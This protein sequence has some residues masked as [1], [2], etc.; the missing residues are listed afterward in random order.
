MPRAE[1]QVNPLQSPSPAGWEQL[2]AA[3]AQSGEAAQKANAPFR[4]LSNAVGALGSLAT[5][6]I[7][8]TKRLADAG[9]DLLRRPLSMLDTA[10]ASINQNITRFVALANPA[11]VMRF[12]LAVNDLYAVIGRALAPALDVM[13]G[14]IRSLGSAIYGTTAQGRTLIAAIAAG[15]VGMI[16]FGAAMAA[17]EAIATG[18]VM[19]IIGALIGAL[20]GMAAVTGMLNPLMESLAPILSG[21]MDQLG[22]VLGVLIGVVQGVLPAL[23]ES[24]TNGIKLIAY[25]GTALE[26]MAPAIGAFVDVIVEIGKAFQPVGE[27][28]IGV[29]VEYVVLLAQAFKAFSPVLIELARIVGSIVRQLVT[30]LREL[31]AVFGVVIPE[32][33]KAPAPG[34]GTRS[35]VGAAVTPARTTDI[36]S[37]LRATRER[38]FS[39]GGA[40]GPPEQ[41]AKNTSAVVEHLKDFKANWEE[42][43]KALAD[44]VVQQLPHQLWE[45]GH[46]VLLAVWRE[47][48][49]IPQQI[50]SEA[51]GMGERGVETPFGKVRLRDINPIPFWIAD[52]ISDQ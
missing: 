42:F 44:W 22:G 14:F 43:K 26:R 30:W 50:A 40:A 37:V 10:I 39:L 3:V 7:Q 41:T 28:L 52:Q 48:K 8:F 1:G 32:F 49:N 5:S 19:P 35:T 9:V 31:L 38:A 4:G 36:E 33:T 34:G 11:A 47:I 23:Q 29:I 18:G 20:G 17:F 16:A 13:T 24:I 12:Q 25:L 45:I 51:S 46:G 21:L 27:F 6:A 15:T 2:S